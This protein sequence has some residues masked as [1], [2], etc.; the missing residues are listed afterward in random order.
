MS[1]KL[2]LLVRGG[3]HLCDQMREQLAPLAAANGCSVDERD[4][5]DDPALAARWGDR[6]PVLLA[7]EHELFHYRIDRA[8]LTAYLAHAPR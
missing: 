5:D 8:A 6:V 4:V 1:I 7:G 3:C 2:T